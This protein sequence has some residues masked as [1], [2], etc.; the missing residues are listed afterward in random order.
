M[1]EGEYHAPVLVDAVLAF[2]E[3]E[4][5]GL[6]L[7]GTV[8]GGGHAEAILRRGPEARLIGMDR[9][10]EAL[11]AARRRLAPFGGRARLVRGNY[12]DAAREVNE[13]LSGALLDLGISS[14]QLDESARGFSYRRGVP[15]DARMAPDVGGRTA[16]DLLNE[17]S[18]A[19]LADVFYRYGEERRSR[20]L[21]GAVVRRRAERRFETSDDLVAV[22]HRALGDRVTERDK[23]RI[24]QS[25]RVVAN[26][27]MGSLE[28]GLPAVRDALGAS[29]VLC[30]ISYHSLESRLTKESFREWSTACTCPPGLPVCVCGGVAQ[31]QELTRRVIVPSAD[32]I[33]GNPRARSAKLRAWRK[34]A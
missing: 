1:G 32:E 9:D 28:R 7:D 24:F 30:I 19:E 17:L 2:L 26:D 11:D 10:Q 14:H 16:A 33:A 3:P 23:A 12:A 22:M 21:A 27:E 31:G 13:P 34:A 8:G 15:L 29:G 6:Y 4:R 18:E 5:G 25:L 20:R